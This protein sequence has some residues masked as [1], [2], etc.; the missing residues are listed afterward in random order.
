VTKATADALGFRL[1]TVHP[2]DNPR[3]IVIEAARSGDM[4]VD[5]GLETGAG[6]ERDTSYLARRVR[7]EADAAC[8]ARSGAA[9]LIHVMLATAYAERCCKANDRAW[10]AES[11]LW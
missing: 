4:G 2:R 5:I 10:L 3:R 8:R 1:S 9:T 11:R 6:A 7:E